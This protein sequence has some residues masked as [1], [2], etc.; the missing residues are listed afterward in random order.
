LLAQ[1]IHLLPLRD[2]AQRAAMRWSS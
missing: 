2:S 1:M